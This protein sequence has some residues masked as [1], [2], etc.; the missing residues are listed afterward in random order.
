MNILLTCPTCAGTSQLPAPHMLLTV[1]KHQPDQQTDGTV[2]WIC[3]TC[4]DL[5]AAKADR[6]AIKTLLAGGATPLAYETEHPRPVHSETA[7]DGGPLTADDLLELHQLLSTN[8]WF[9]Q[10]NSLVD[11]VTAEPDTAEHLPPLSQPEQKGP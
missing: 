6:T 7:V 4:A 8:S 5:I 2:A 1:G 3:L 10:L 11:G 9:E